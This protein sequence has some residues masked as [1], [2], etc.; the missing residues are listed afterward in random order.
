M[1]QDQ[2]EQSLGYTLLW[3]AQLHFDPFTGVR[4]IWLF[5]LSGC[6]LAVEP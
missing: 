5:R 4:L 3:P 2:D 6:N 1:K